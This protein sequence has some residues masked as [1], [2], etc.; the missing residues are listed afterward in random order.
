MIL[1]ESDSGSNLLFS[2]INDC[3][4][5]AVHVI[6]SFMLEKLEVEDLRK[7][8]LSRNKEGRKFL[9]QL[10]EKAFGDFYSHSLA[11]S[12]FESYLKEVFPFILEELNEEERSEISFYEQISETVMFSTKNFFEDLA[13]DKDCD[14]FLKLFQHKTEHGDNIFHCAAFNRIHKTF[15]FLL[16]QARSLFSEMEIKELLGSPGII[17][18]IPLFLAFEKK[19]DDVT[20]SLDEISI[21]KELIFWFKSSEKSNVVNSIYFVIENYSYQSYEAFFKVL[22]EVSKAIDFDLELRKVLFELTDA[23]GR[24]AIMLAARNTDSK[25]IEH[26]WSLVEATFDD[27]EKRKEIL[28]PFDKTGINAYCHAAIFPYR[29]TFFFV[30]N[31]YLK[32]GLF[33]KKSRSY[34]NNVQTAKNRRRHT[35]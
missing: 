26:F 17:C 5:Q 6:W 19:S 29:E 10:K 1:R 16:D 31:L 18:Q 30:E 33:L 2:C 11:I 25:V 22:N 7:I 20:I 14:F 27:V 9:L 15:D 35:F 12:I 13:T 4:R 3:E 8:L 21:T 23:L 28:Q 32:L 24:T 34:I